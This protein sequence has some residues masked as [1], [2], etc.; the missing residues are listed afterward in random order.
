[1]IV[2][3]FYI[4]RKHLIFSKTNPPRLVF[5]LKWEKYAKKERRIRA[6]PRDLFLQYSLNNI[7]E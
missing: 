4:H 1:M 7:L 3:R 5:S 2:G 6:F